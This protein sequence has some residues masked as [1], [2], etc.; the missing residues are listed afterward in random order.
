MDDSARITAIDDPTSDRVPPD[1]VAPPA[2]PQPRDRTALMVLLCLASVYVI[3]GSTYLAIRVALESFAPFQMAGVRFLIAGGLLFAYLKLRGQRAPTAR[4][5]RNAAVTGVLLLVGG[6][7]LVCYA[8]QTVSSGLAAV[9][10]ASM[11]LFAALFA[12][13][14]GKWPDRRDAIGLAIGFAGVIALNFGGSM[15]ASP[16]GAIA[17][18]GAPIA[19]AFGSVWSKH[20]DM[21][22][23]M[24]STAAQMLAGG[25]ALTL[26]SL[27][28]GESL[29]HAPTLRATL[30]VVY[31]IGAGSLM[32]LTAYIWLLGHVRPALATSYAYVNPPLAVL[33]GVALAGETIGAT[34]IA[35]MLVIL[36]GVALI[37]RSRH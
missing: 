11:P 28:I 5:W 3:W 9:A 8:E 13:A 21:P 26:I 12:G 7:G 19:W 36:G 24:M 32:G 4:Q 17:L 27:G 1:P 2:P 35:A 34:E 30:A 31:L 20:Q 22:T 16:L 18:I 14:Y 29:P 37:L 6:N 25:V 10:V 15:R 33:M 23:A